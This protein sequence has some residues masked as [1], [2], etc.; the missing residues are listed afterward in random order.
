MPIAIRGETP[1]GEEFIQY[2]KKI[3]ISL[4]DTLNFNFG[5]IEEV[6]YSLFIFTFLNLLTTLLINILELKLSKKE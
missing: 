4:S 3:K 5:S 6:H 1:G 2:L